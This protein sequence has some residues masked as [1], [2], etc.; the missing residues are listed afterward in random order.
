MIM[1]MTIIRTRR[2]FSE[3][4]WAMNQILSNS[5]YRSPFFKYHYIYFR[6]IYLWY[7]KNFTKKTLFWNIIESYKALSKA[8]VSTC[9]SLSSIMQKKNCSSYISK[10]GTKSDWVDFSATRGP[11]QLEWDFKVR[12]LWLQRDKSGGRGCILQRGGT[13]QNT[14]AE[15]QGDFQPPQT[16]LN[17]CFD[18]HEWE[19][20]QLRCTGRGEQL[21]ENCFKADQHWGEQW[22]ELW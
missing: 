11:K 19:K 1:I 15:K 14:S 8:E 5:T 3:K 18:L 13:R 6:N 20:M 4:F 17:A 16:K 22:T 10:S 21:F 9:H 2:S 7:K 12:L